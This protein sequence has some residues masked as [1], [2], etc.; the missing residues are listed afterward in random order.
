MLIF[1]TQGHELRTNCIGGKP[2][3]QQRKILKKKCWGMKLL[4]NYSKKK[5]QKKN[6][7]QHELTY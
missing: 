4:K 7:T 2:K 1:K 6:L 3:K 5:Q